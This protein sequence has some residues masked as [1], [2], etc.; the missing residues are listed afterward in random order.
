TNG[1]LKEEIKSKK[2][3]EFDDIAPDRLTLWSVSF[4]DNDNLQRSIDS[5]EMKTLRATN[6][7]DAVFREDPPK[8]QFTSSSNDKIQL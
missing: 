4:P 5:A 7:L 8:I 2:A 3:P 1:D 6:E